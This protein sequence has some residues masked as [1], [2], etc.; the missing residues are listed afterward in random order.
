MGGAQAAASSAAA[1]HGTES[2]HSAG[3]PTLNG[4]GVKIGI[5]DVG[6]KGWEEGLKSSELPL[7]PLSRRFCSGFVSLAT[8]IATQW[9][10]RATNRILAAWDGRH[11]S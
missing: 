7:V 9:V 11:C 5:I 4:A 6:F 3:H 1:A 8:G 10:G 2:W